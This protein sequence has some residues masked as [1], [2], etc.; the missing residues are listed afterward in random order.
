MD[1]P[2]EIP[3]DN[4]LSVDA[5]E[6]ETTGVE[7][8]EPITQEEE[9]AP[10][11]NMGDMYIILLKSR[12]KPFLAKI[13]EI[14][15][16]E[17][18]VEF[19]DDSGKSVAFRIKDDQI[20]QKAE[21]YEIIEMIRVRKL[22]PK[23]EKDEEITEALEVEFDTDELLDKQYSTLAKQD[24][25]LNTMIKR[26]NIYDNPLLIN[27]AQ[28]CIDTFIQLIELIDQLELEDTSEALFPSGMIPIVGNELKLYDNALLYEELSSEL[29]DKKSDFTGYQNYVEKMLKYQEPFVPEGGPGLSTEDFQGTFLRDCLQS[30][31]CAGIGEPYAY[32]ERKS[33][34][35]MLQYA[36]EG[37]SSQIGLLLASERLRIVSVIVEP[38][39]RSIWSI[40]QKTF[41]KFTILEKNMYLNFWRQSQTEKK[42]NMSELNIIGSVP[43]D[44]ETYDNDTFLTY[45]ISDDMQL[46]DIRRLIDANDVIDK[47]LEDEELCEYL[48]NFN[49]I[50]QV[51]FKYRISISQINP[52]NYEKIQKLF[53]KN[54]RKYQ[55][56]YVR[57]VKKLDVKEPLA[58][59]KNA[60]TNARRVELA[61]DY[62]FN[63]MK[64][65]EKNHYLQVFIDNFTRSA[66][67]PRESRDFL[68]NKFTNEQI[69]CRH[70]L[71][72]VNA[73]N[74]NE[75]FLSL[76]STYGL[77]AQDGYISCRCCGAYLCPE[78]T[79]M[80]DG[81]DD[82]KPIQLRE[83]MKEDE[84]TVQVRVEYLE[85]QET[86]V[87]LIECLGNAIG[88][89]LTDNDKYEIL[90]SYELMDN[91]L[92]SEARYD[93]K[94]V[95]ENRDIHPRVHEKMETM[96]KAIRE[97][98]NKQKKKK[99]R[100][101][102]ETT[103]HNFQKWL[104]DTNKILMI[105][106]LVSV[107]IQT[108]VPAFIFKKGIVFQIFDVGTKSI[109]R[110]SL[111]YLVVKIKKLYAKYSKDP[112][113]SSIPDL[114]DESKYTVNDIV[115]Q[116][117]NT[118]MYCV[119]HNNPPMIGRLQKYTD[120]LMSQDR[121]YL[122]EEWTMFR[123]LSGNKLIQEVNTELTE[124]VEE[125]EQL[126]KR[127]YGGIPIENVSLVRALTLSK[128]VSPGELCKIPQFEIIKNTAFNRLFKY[129]ISCYG[130]HESHVF[131]IMTI[132]RMIDTTQRSKELVEILKK[133]GWNADTGG[134]TS[135][136]INF[137]LLREKIVPD[138]LALYG[139][140]NSELKSCYSN[141]SACNSY[142]HNSVNNYD[143][144][145]LNTFPKRVYGY[146]LDKVYP[147]LSFDRLKQEKPKFVAKVFKVYK[148]NN[149]GHIVRKKPE[150][151]YDKFLMMTTIIE[152]PEISIDQYHNLESNA[153]TFDAI[154]TDRRIRYSLEHNE[155]QQRRENFSVEDYERTQLYSI[156]EDNFLE[157]LQSHETP[158]ISD[159]EEV[160]HDELMHLCQDYITLI[161]NAE[162][163]VA[164]RNILLER[165]K[166]LFSQC[167][168]E[169]DM[170]L[171]KLVDF[172]IV[173][174]EIE[175]K[176]KQLLERGLFTDE[177]KL[178]K[179]TRENLFNVLTKFTNDVEF[180]TIHVQR[181]LS[182]IRTVFNHVLN[183]KQF[184]PTE[185]PKEWKLT[186]SIERTLE[187]FIQRD[188]ESCMLLLHN[189][190][191]AIQSRDHYPGFNRYLTENPNDIIYIRGLFQYVSPL[192]KE[193]DLICGSDQED[194][195]FTKRYSDIYMKY[196]FIKFFGL[197]LEYIQGLRD[198][199]SE[200]ANDA[201]DLFASLE[202]RDEALL[203]ESIVTCSRF[204]MDLVTHILLAHYDTTWLFMNEH[205]LDLANRLS[206]QKESEK[207]SFI[208]QF[209][210][211]SKDE[212]SIMIQKQKMGIS[213]WHREGAERAEK[214]VNS[215]AY[216]D[217]TEEER[218]TILKD[219][220]GDVVAQDDAFNEA[221]GN[222]NDVNPVHSYSAPESEDTGY[223]ELN[224][225]DEEHD[226]SMRGDEDAGSQQEF[227]E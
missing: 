202:M 43:D 6:E 77:P 171:E 55:V 194:A 135:K 210:D 227:N 47:L 213:N 131:I 78:D 177:G 52:K 9:D 53:Q 172:M 181:Y 21:E 108:A 174:T 76:K 175:R 75:V 119:G 160:L 170:Q 220:E 136:S 207:Q 146:T 215:Q 49:D 164:A 157:Y 24:D 219:I 158:W 90:Q 63:L 46:D 139:E 115:K 168:S 62:I 180:G 192:F 42:T 61:H 191:F 86:I 195:F 25:L 66:G 188:T 221:I 179:Y 167:I 208:D 89:A 72:S 103:F 100:A 151:F 189:R 10:A 37:E 198:D 33:R 26:M 85:K 98:K 225:L 39:N 129:I 28:E 31:T 199:R 137:K 41:R 40:D 165:R 51:L 34:R 82:D 68:Y 69:L 18:I 224:E 91:V 187:N 218:R 92:L 64:E 117:A 111:E 159:T 162:D 153:E 84:Q 176:Q 197:A 32:D 106:A 95:A 96:V 184:L 19:E 216:T 59:R 13:I 104:K 148:K 125:N 38:I 152:K 83:V 200:I 1:D 190:I 112:L 163:N 204:V 27:R 109:H 94:G 30:E 74:N 166:T 161:S 14:Q 201:N 150:Y 118:I 3:T 203:D 132:Q 110:Q 154:F 99:M 142:I 8:D 214:Y 20:V 45:T 4:P 156:I 87:K 73:K 144:T 44:T 120:F 48:M 57:K 149:L 223:I 116:L 15:D 212:R 143:L 29:K 80:F 23:E 217:H 169:R 17:D 2:E 127:V 211:L 205:K 65:D 50:E 209:D 58:T 70:Y 196:L 60:L 185:F 7:Q 54:I 11:V 12:D 122:K 140:D 121:L 35:L 79:S 126:L 133:H 5:F 186:E 102:R 105:T 138:I 222:R 141:S 124:V 81:F 56:E 134:F 155:I 145:L 22:D 193:I 206:K 183:N 36:S 178:K 97:E 93:L 173:S 101:D 182:D 88:I 113:W 107:Y 123:P 226:E 114:I 67:N 128:D 130:I 147:E 16:S 71:Y